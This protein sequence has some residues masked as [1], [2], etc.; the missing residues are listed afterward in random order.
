MTSD[1]LQNNLRERILWHMA[2][3]GV[4]YVQMDHAQIK[5]QCNVTGRYARQLVLLNQSPSLK[6]L[7]DLADYFGTTIIDLLLP[8]DETYGN[9]DESADVI[10]VKQNYIRSNNEG[11]RVITGVAE[12]AS[13]S[14]QREVLP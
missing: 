6:K 4:N 10:R 2:K 11:K 1:D 14:Q 3:K 9:T 12:Y 8:L 5:G 13:R 7:E